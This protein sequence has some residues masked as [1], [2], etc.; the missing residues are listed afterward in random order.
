[1]IGFYPLRDKLNSQVAELVRRCCGAT[2][3][4]KNSISSYDEV[5]IIGYRFKSCPDYKKI[6]SYEKI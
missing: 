1:V 3:L 2:P 6:K 4:Y 5:Q